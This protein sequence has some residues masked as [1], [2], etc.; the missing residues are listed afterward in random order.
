MDKAEKK[1][2]L[3]AVRLQERRAFLDAMPLSIESARRLFG[4]VSSRLPQAGCD[5]TLRLTR[6]WLAAEDVEAAPV[7]AWLES[8]GGFCDCEVLNVEEAVEDAAKAADER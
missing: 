6:A 7:V 1:R 5:H 2:R 3:A 8:H 4:A